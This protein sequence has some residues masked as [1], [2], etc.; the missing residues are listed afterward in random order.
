[1]SAVL[2]ISDFDWRAIYANRIRA[3]E[4]LY[5]DTHTNLL[6]WGRWGRD[7]F[8]GRPRLMLSGIW[9]L[10]GETDPDRDPE[11][12]PEGRPARIDERMVLNLDARINHQDFPSVWWAVLKANYIPPKFCF[13]I[14]PEY[15]RP[16]AAGV[17]AES[18]I[19]QLSN[20]LDFLRA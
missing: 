10:P 15:Q 13:H 2:K 7:R 3:I 8:P 12:V 1:M 14:A 19:E 20:A 16:N 6:E 11:A 9:T 18:Y 4:E 5:G 17:G